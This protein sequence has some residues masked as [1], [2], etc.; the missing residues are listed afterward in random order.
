MAQTVNVFCAGSL[1]A[2][3]TKI[4]QSDAFKDLGIEA[5]FGPSGYLKEQILAGKPC[6]LFISAN[7]PLADDIALN[8]KYGA[9]LICRN[10]MVLS[11]RAERFP[12][13]DT[14]WTV[15][16]D[17]S[18]RLGGHDPAIS[19]CGQYAQEIL[20]DIY[21]M[22]PYLGDHLKERYVVLENGVDG[23]TVPDDLFPAEY[24]LTKQLCDAYLGYGS[25]YRARG[26]PQ[27]LRVLPL[28][29]ITTMKT[30][31]WSA[32][33]PENQTAVKFRDY[34]LSDEGQQILKEGGF[35]PL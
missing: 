25:F 19:P 22:E 4:V 3:V 24:F 13:P 16:R 28:T 29:D 11:V 21:K 9:K 26:I 14:V 27:T 10:D 6:D 30:E 32:C 35:L 2:P 1:K 31:C 18:I 5:T 33:N 34:L 15:L 17:E 20:D 8:K 7:K 23:Q 12:A